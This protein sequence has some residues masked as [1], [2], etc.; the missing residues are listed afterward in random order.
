MYHYNTN[1]AANIPFTGANFTEYYKT[2]ISGIVGIA[3]SVASGAAGI[4]SAVNSALNV[5]CNKLQINKSSNISSNYGYLDVK[6]PYLIITRPI[7]SVPSN[8][9]QYYGYPLNITTELN[10]LSG[11]TEVEEI[12][13]EGLNLNTLEMSELDSLLKSGVIL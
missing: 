7:Q 1:I 9:K 4:G 3:S 5:A 12:H 10:T 6:Y 11:Y 8:F 2:A 13:L